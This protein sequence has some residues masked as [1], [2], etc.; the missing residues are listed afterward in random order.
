MK[1]LLVGNPNVGKSA[2]FSQLTGI[3]V[4]TSNYPGTTVNY[5][6]GYMTYNDKQSEL[7][8]VPGTYHLEPENEAEKVAIDMISQGDIIINVVDATNLERNLNLTLQLMEFQKPMVIALNLW[9]EA[10]HKGIG[11]DIEKLEELLKVPIIATNGLTGEGLVK[12]QN[13]CMKAKSA[14][15]PKCSSDLRWAKIGQIVSK[16]QNLTYRR[17]TFMEQIQDLS[18][19]PSL[20]PMLAGLSLFI[21]FGFIISVGEK[22]VEFMETVFQLFFTPIIL[23]LSDII[24]E[25]EII[26]YLLIGNIEGRVIEYEE[27]MGVL[28]TGVFVAFGLVLPYIVLFYLIL[29]FFRRLGVFTACCNHV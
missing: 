9:D 5:T 18:I 7:I 12:L 14:H 11:I 13:E 23:W 20:G 21:I 24:K 28:T 17:H 8:D 2:I 6:K 25:Q 10:Q 27:A 1:V 22:I 3:S 15:W 16:V 4:T 19:H 29:G 26:H